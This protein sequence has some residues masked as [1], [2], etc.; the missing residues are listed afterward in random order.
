MPRYIDAEALEKKALTVYNVH[1]GELS[2]KAV[3]VDDINSAPTVDAESVRH[4]CWRS[5]GTCTSC[6]CVAKWPHSEYCPH[7]GAR[8]DLINET[9]VE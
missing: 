4:G 3:P 1:G 8:M 9:G 7:C 5:D 6:D 2:W